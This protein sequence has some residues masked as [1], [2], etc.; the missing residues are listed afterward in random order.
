MTQKNTQNSK[1]TLNQTTKELLEELRH[2]SGHSYGELIEA[3]LK[4]Y[5]GLLNQPT[6]QNNTTVDLTQ[7]AGDLLKSL[8]GRTPTQ[9]QVIEAALNVYKNQVNYHREANG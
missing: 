3:A 6:K 1:L 5:Q 7:T 2:V 4:Y 8:V 9:G